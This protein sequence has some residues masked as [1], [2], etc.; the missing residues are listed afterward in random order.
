MRRRFHFALSPSPI[1]MSLLIDNAATFVI[2]REVQ[3]N[4]RVIHVCTLTTLAPVAREL[5]AVAR[6]T[7][8]L[9]ERV[10]D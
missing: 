5:I 6:E 10:V 7:I 8:R 1:T 4:V 3:V 2:S 9:H